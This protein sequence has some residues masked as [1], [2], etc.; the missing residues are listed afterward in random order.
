MICD[1][2][3]QMDIRMLPK[4]MRPMPLVI[5]FEGE[6]ITTTWTD[7]HFGCRRQWFLCPSCDR[8]CAVIYMKDGGPLWGCR[9]CLDGRYAS[10][11]KS[12][13]ARRLQ[14]AFTMRERLGQTESNLHLP[15]PER[16]RHI[17]HRTYE[18]IR[19]EAQLLEYE[20]SLHNIAFI[21]KCSVEE[22]RAK[23]A[24]GKLH[25]VRMLD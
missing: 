11:R 17:H 22:I 20:I 3:K 1:E 2:T 18:R 8:R 14:K 10:E 4:E 6:Q 23:L 16:P 7:M 19:S 21:R 5:H 15:F 25:V 12:S 13:Q 24:E 9:L